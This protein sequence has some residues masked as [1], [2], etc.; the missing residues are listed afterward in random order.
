MKIVSGLGQP[1]SAKVR[2][3]AQADET[4]NRACFSVVVHDGDE[5]GPLRLSA[6]DFTPEKNGGGWLEIST[7]SALNEPITQLNVH[8]RCSAGVDLNRVYTVF[9]DPPVVAPR[10]IN[11]TAASAR[12][13]TSVGPTVVA[14]VVA[15]PSATAGTPR[16]ANGTSPLAVATATSSTNASITTAGGDT[17]AAIAA[18]RYP[19]E[20][21]ARKLFIAKIRALNPGLGTD[22]ATALPAGTRLQLPSG[23][24]TAAHPLVAAKGEWTVASGESFFAIVRKLYPDQPARKRALVALMRQLNPDLP[25]DGEKPLPAGMQLKLPTRLDRLPTQD[26]MA[27]VKGG[28]SKHEAVPGSNAPPSNRSPAPSS[29]AQTSAPATQAGRLVVSGNPKPGKAQDAAI[30]QLQDKETALTDQISDQTAKLNEA[31]YRID[32]LEKRMNTM[33]AELA[34][35]EQEQKAAEVAHQKQLQ[36][37]KRTQWASLAGVAAGSAALIGLIAFLLHR[38]ARK[39]DSASEIDLLAPSLPDPNDS[40]LWKDIHEPK[41]PVRASNEPIERP[42]PRPSEADMDVYFLSNVASEATL[43][44]AHGQYEQAVALLKS[45]VDRHPTQVVNWMQLLELMHG[46]RDVE[47]FVDQASIFR[48]R[49]ASEALWERVARLGRELAPRHP[50][51]ADAAAPRGLAPRTAP[52]PEADSAEQLKR[53]LDGLDEPQEPDVDLQLEFEEPAA[54]QPLDLSIA[55]PPVDQADEEPVHLHFDAPDALPAAVPANHAAGDE[56]HFEAP[57]LF[58]VDPQPE[59][60]EAIEIG[61]LPSAGSKIEAPAPRQIDMT[62]VREGS[63]E[64]AHLLL[65]AGRREEGAAMLERLMLIGSL[66]ERLAAAEMLVK[67]TSPL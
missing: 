63:M 39:R 36:A 57:L 33:V 34:R 49:F 61:A 15:T 24:L 43:L 27:A 47:E 12:T 40:M 10:V 54:D 60:E 11:E 28:A 8:M 32:K 7:Q 21:D 14:P 6:H 5:T 2:I 62:N 66:E 42:Q 4:I 56:D 51:F 13:P 35:R 19:N 25:R 23:A 41:A 26:D 45:E 31:N 64:H 44:A 52:A 37:A 16:V 58:D 50:L 20:P 1:L 53:V 65:D 9:L 67:L 48:E 38:S 18:Q 30:Q 17:L 46:H 3:N 55:V 29:P 22:D 59:P